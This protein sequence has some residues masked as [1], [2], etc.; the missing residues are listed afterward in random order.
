MEKF[1]EFLEENNARENF[2]R[3]FRNYNR[4]VKGYKKLC[5]RDIT[6]ALVGAFPWVYMK[7]GYDYW[8]DLNRKWKQVWMDPTPERRN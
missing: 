4:D 5:E 6:A 1:I 2:E 8:S 3:T 7:E